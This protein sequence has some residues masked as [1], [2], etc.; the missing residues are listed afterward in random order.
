MQPL[1]AHAKLYR[2][3]VTRYAALPGETRTVTANAAATFRWL[4]LPGC[5]QLSYLDRRYQDSE[6]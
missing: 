6:R 3:G 5:V 2:G 4:W 1:G